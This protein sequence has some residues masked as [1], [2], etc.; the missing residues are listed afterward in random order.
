MISLVAATFYGIFSAAPTYILKYAVDNVFVK[1]MQNLI[2]PFACA[3]VFISLIKGVFA[4]ASLYYMHWVGNMVVNDIRADLFSK[5]V[6]FPLS[7]FKKK[8]TGELMSHFLNDIA[9]IQQAAS[10]AIKD[11]VR[12]FFEA[13]FLLGIALTQNWKLSLLSFVVAP[14]I[15]IS[16]SNI[17]RKVKSAS[18][19]IQQDVGLI[20]SVLQEIF[21]GIREVKVFNGEKVEQKRFRNSLNRYFGSVMRNVRVEAFGPTLIE[22]IAMVGS[23]FVFYVAAHQVISGAI[24]PGSLTA[25]FAAILLSYQPIKRLC[26]TY[27]EVQYGLAAGTRVFEIM[28][29]TYDAL[30]DR[31]RTVESFKEAI[32]FQNVSFG[33]HEDLVLRDVNLVIR[34][35]ERI[36]LLGP[37]GSG[38]S[39]FCDLLLGF[40][41]PVKGTLLVDGVDITKISLESLR[42]LVGSVSQQTFL[43]NDTIEANVKYAYDEATHAQIIDA[44]RKAHACDFIEQAPLGYQ[45]SVGENGT[46]LSGGQKQRITIARALLKNPDILIFDEAT[47][48]LDN[49]S[50]ETIRLAIEEI[51]RT[52]TLIVVSHRV[53][54]IEKMDRIFSIEHGHLVEQ[55]HIKKSSEGVQ[56]RA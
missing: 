21:V 16:I 38:K 55:T 37:S 40:V 24:T 32:V 2:V 4:Y 15:V 36:G 30:K 42:A 23:G 49:K 46:L 45:S 26:N 33:Y 1:G 5:I 56:Q 43:F 25:F 35:G 10:S 12:S 28:D 6:Y 19:A 47:S 20:S 51:N 22:A 13:I 41:S 31:N 11:G 39:T 7:F 53:S 44:C 50:E 29:M 9:K 27:T 52:K 18:R 3:F 14:F 48:A 34:K 8:T 54:L 17:G